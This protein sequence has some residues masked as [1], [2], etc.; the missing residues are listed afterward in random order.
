M[1]IHTQTEGTFTGAFSFQGSG[2]DSDKACAY[3]SRFTAQM[4]PD[5]RVTTLYLDDPLT[6]SFFGCSPTTDRR[7]AGTVTSTAIRFEVTDRPTCQ[8]L[9]GRVREFDRTFTI[10]VVRPQ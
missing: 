10:S 1:Y 3:G 9:S 7:S 5:G 2:S 4:T 8:D 6:G